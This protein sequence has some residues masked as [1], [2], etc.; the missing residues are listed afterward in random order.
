MIQFGLNFK[1]G[2][3]SEKIENENLK[4]ES[5]KGSITEQIQAFH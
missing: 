3:K 5:Q 2:I 4:L 1:L